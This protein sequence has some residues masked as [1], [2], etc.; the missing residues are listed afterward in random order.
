MKRTFFLAGLVLVATAMLAASGQLMSA[1]LASLRDM[2]DI[3]LPLAS[4]LPSLEH[5]LDVLEK[6]V[7]LSQLQAQL[8][9]GSPEEAMRMYV[10]PGSGGDTRT[11]ALLDVTASLL[12]QQGMLKG[13]SDIEVGEIEPVEGAPVAEHGDDML[14]GRTYTFSGRLNEQ[15]LTQLLQVIDLSGF[16]TVGDTL[17][18]EETGRLFTLT[19]LEDYAGIVPLEKFLNTDLIA[20]AREPK[21]HDEALL[22]SLSSDTF[23]QEFRSII[24]ASRLGG[25]QQIIGGPWGK[26]YSAQKLLPMPFL[27]LE[28]V[29][30]DDAKDGW[31]RVKVVVR[32]YE[33][34]GNRK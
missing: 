20:Y 24:N 31:H 26:A 22:R 32:A 3:S 17:R 2:R 10:L 28:K 7:E 15:G 9:T 27:T 19:E 8:R 12:T 33:R 29:G 21:P 16:L 6:Q 30:M 25:A 14:M 18:P 13:M 34:L 4:T 5:R 1:H 11:L 23:L